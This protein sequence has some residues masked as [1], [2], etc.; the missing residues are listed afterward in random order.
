[1]LSGILHFSAR[2]AIRAVDPVDPEREKKLFSGAR[3]FLSLKIKL[4]LSSIL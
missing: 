4:A 2:L 3:P 1:M